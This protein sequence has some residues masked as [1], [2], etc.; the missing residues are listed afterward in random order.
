M[1]A[2]SLANPQQLTDVASI[3]IP[4][5]VPLAVLAATGVLYLVLRRKQPDAQNM[6][7]F[8]VVFGLF[9]LITNAWFVLA[10]WL[11]TSASDLPGGVK[12]AALAFFVITIFINVTTAS[13]LLKRLSDKNDLTS[14]WFRQHHSMAAVGV[15]VSAGH[16]TSIEILSSRILHLEA[17]SADL[18]NHDQQV[19]MAVQ[20]L[21]FFTEDIPMVILQAYV[22]ATASLGVNTIAQT[23]GYISLV[24]SIVSLLFSG[25][26]RLFY[27]IGERND[28]QRRRKATLHAYESELYK[29]TSQVAINRPPSMSTS[30]S[31]STGAFELTPVRE[32]SMDWSSVGDTPLPSPPP[33]PPV[34]PPPPPTRSSATGSLAPTTSCD[35][36]AATTASDP[37][38]PATAASN[39]IARVDPPSKDGGVGDL[40]VGT[41]RAARRRRHHGRLRAGRRWQRRRGGPARQRARRSDGEPRRCGRERT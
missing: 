30:A 5:V 29:Q 21:T 7:V 10:V 4:I 40:G 8:T 19:I 6:I 16:L 25:I 22:V 33:P 11:N 35:A 38:C 41:E 36:A 24:V 23:F 37:A 27:W 34:L 2:A 3:V 26:Q 14:R 9:N 28:R 18:D 39:T 32:I 13:V 31:A 1:H 17:F 12:E 20:V 15:V